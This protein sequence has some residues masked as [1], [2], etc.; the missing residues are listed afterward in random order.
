MK[1]DTRALWNQALD[2][3]VTVGGTER[4]RTIFYTALYRSLGRMTDITEDGRYFS[5]YDH[6]VHNAEGHDF[7][8]D[9]GPLGYIPILTSL[10]T[11]TRSAPA[12]RY[13]ALL[14]SHV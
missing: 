14:Y 8:I 6:A 13:G 10:A 12:G 5:A 9:D 4:Q 3:I 7:Y 11:L 1:S 2:G